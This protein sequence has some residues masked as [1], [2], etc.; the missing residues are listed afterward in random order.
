[1]YSD[2]WRG[3]PVLYE[4]TPTPASP[5]N[6]VAPTFERQILRILRSSSSRCGGQGFDAPL[7]R[8]R[9][10][11]AQRYAAIA[12]MREEYD[13]ARGDKHWVSKLPIRSLTISERPHAPRSCRSNHLAVVHRV[14]GERV[15]PAPKPLEA[16]MLERWNE[17]EPS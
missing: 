14:D 1:M 6:K 9:A 17:R 12:F 8:G 5:S 13:G 16:R 3:P 15:Q 2:Y 10:A 11:E 4:R 7:L